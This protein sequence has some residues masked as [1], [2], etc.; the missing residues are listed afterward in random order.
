MANTNTKTKTIPAFQSEEEE[1]IFWDAHD[2]EEY[3]DKTPAGHLQHEARPPV[4]AGD[5]HSQRPRGE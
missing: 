5:S 2:P 1:L 4:P 3:F